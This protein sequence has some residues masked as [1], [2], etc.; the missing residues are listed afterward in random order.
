MVLVLCFCY[1]LWWLT[2]VVAVLLLLV[3]GGVGGAGAGGK[4]GG[5]WAG[6][7][8]RGFGFRVESVEASRGTERTPK[9]GVRS[10]FCVYTGKLEHQ[11]ERTLNFGVCPPKPPATPETSL[12]NPPPDRPLPPILFPDPLSPKMSICHHHIDYM[13]NSSDN[14]CNIITIIINNSSSNSINTGIVLLGTLVPNIQPRKVE[15]TL[16][17]WFLVSNPGLVER[18]AEC[19]EEWCHMP[20]HHSVKLVVPPS[21]FGTFPMGWPLK[22]CGHIFLDP[23]KWLQIFIIFNN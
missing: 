21:Y 17:H 19:L 12:Q 10:V 16:D 4:C 5:C 7:L 23:M 8:G 13:S 20:K 15:Q 14:N 18:Q 3:V 1:W 9:L 2:V 6:G 22:R 11:I